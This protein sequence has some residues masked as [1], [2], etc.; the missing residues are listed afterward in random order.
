MPISYCVYNNRFSLSKF[1]TFYLKAL[2]T[3][4]KKLDNEYFNNI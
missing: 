2:R 4:K 3:L 1:R